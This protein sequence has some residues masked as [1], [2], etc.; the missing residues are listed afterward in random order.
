[1]TNDNII[2]KNNTIYIT[3]N[4]IVNANHNNNNKLVYSSFYLSPLSE[5]EI[6][7]IINDISSKKSI[8]IN[9][10]DFNLNKIFSCWFY[11][12]TSTLYFKFAI[13]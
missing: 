2:N 1:M 12:Q 3:N 4:N 10:I 11:N 7:P 9:N 6:M 5:V 8:D 13:Y